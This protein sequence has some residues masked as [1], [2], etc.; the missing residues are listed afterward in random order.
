MTSLSTLLTTGNIAMYKL[1]CK[2]F[3][4]MLPAPGICNMLSSDQEI[5]QSEIKNE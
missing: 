3:L 5:E 4:T 2:I 1:F